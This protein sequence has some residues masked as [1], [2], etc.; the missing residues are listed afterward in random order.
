[1]RARSYHASGSDT[2]ERTDIRTVKDSGG[3]AHG[4]VERDIVADNA[5]LHK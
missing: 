4:A 2:H 5:V 3:I 1:M